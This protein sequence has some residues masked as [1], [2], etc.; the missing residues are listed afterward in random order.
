MKTLL[1]CLV[2]ATQAMAEPLTELPGITPEEYRARFE[3]KGYAVKR[4]ANRDPNL[5]F[6]S[7]SASKTVEGVAFYISAGV[8]EE[9]HIRNI[10]AVVMRQSR[11]EFRKGSRST[12]FFQSV[13]ST[14][15][16]ES[17]RKEPEAWISTAMANGGGSTTI[18]ELHY[19]I[20]MD[21]EGTIRMRIGASPRG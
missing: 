18:Q 9:R 7:W 12:E 15:L 14:V 17:M 1:L 21:E 20:W 2:F 5:P 8:V 16:P 19:D 4:I 13:M 10:H 11:D 6:R 3:A